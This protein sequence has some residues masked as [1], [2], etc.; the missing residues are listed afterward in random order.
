MCSSDLFKMR[1]AGRRVAGLY[2]SESERVDMA[3]RKFISKIALALVLLAHAAFA[4]AQNFP[5]KPIRW[6]V[7]FPPGGAT[8]V[9]VRLIQPRF[10]ERIGQPVV[11]EN[12]GGAGG[13]IGH[14]AVAKA[15]NDGHTLLYAIPALVLN[16][17]FLK[18][19]VDPNAFTGVIQTTGL[20]SIL[21][22][23]TA[24]GAKPVADIIA[25]IKA[26][27][28]TVSCATPGSLPTVGCYLLQAHA[29]AEMIMVNYKGN[30]PALTALMG[31]EINMMFDLGPTVVGPVKGGKVHAIATAYPKRG[32]APF[33]ELPAV[34]ETV[35]GFDLTAWQG[36]VVAAGTPREAIGR[37]NRDIDA[38]LSTPEVRQRLG[39]TGVD[40][41]G[42]SADA[43]DGLLKRDYKRF[44]T[45]LKAAGIKPE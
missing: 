23:S 36:V 2:P 5:A 14:E 34:A 25:M 17:V 45:V 40:V 19:A 11:V 37:L 18:V 8:D 39:E 29:G 4:G 15:G 7:P 24:F 41:I 10:S 12:I 31:G 20:T 33:P 28:G 44:T 13:N 43:F 32:A 27:P 1:T 30:A 42:G 26:K 9:V 38:V 35:P 21:V 16:P 3:L 22:S 6:V